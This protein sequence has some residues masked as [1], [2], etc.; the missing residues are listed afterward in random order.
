MATTTG[1]VNSNFVLNIVE[2][3]NTITSAS[4]VSLA[5]TVSQLQQMVQF[6][7]KT[8]AVNNITAFDTTPI[9]VTSDVN[10]QGTVTGGGGN[11]TTGGTSITTVDTSSATAAAVQIAVPTGTAMTIYGDGHAVFTNTVSATSFITLSDARYKTHVTPLT[12]SLDRVCAL[13]GVN[14][15]WGG[16]P[17]GGRKAGFLAQEVAAVIP[18]A[19]H[20]DACDDL[21]SVEPAAIVPYL[22]EAIKTLTARVKALE[23]RMG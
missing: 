3:Q 6:D 14:Y 18:E 8:V 15:V 4:G 12:D 1:G 11:L 23:Q 5:D 2:L 7:T 13:Q 19:G 17:T 10:F 22:V 21:W 16:R 9:Q 20:Y